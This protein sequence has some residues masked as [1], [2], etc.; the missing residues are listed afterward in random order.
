[1][2]TELISPFS[3]Q[4]KEML[5]AKFNFPSFDNQ[6]AS[7]GHHILTPH[8]HEIDVVVIDVDVIVVAKKVKTTN[9]PG[10]E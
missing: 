10:R 6:T 1:M 3:E 5:D 2:I 7:H 4:T 9:Q 8:H